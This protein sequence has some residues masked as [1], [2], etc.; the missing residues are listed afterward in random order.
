MTR[1]A[2]ILLVDDEVSIQRAVAPLLRARGYT[3]EVVGSGAAAL[4]ALASQP[5]D[6]IV[7]DLGLP[8]IDGIELCQRLREESKAPVVVLS[9]RSGE[10]G[11]VKVL[12]L[13]ADD[14][15]TKPFSP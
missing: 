6:L 11:K 1:P 15:I 7:L 13:G 5:P 8:D 3:V 9:A 2:R 4:E 12:D 14:Y 10:T